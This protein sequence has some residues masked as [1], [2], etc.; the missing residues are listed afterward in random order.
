MGE[1]GGERSL[2]DRFPALRR[3]AISGRRR[4]R[5]RVPFVQQTTV[6]DCGAACLAM[7]LGHHGKTVR[8]DAVRDVAGVSGRGLNAGTLLEVGRHFGLRGRG[9][10][11]ADV[12]FLRFLEPGAILHWRFK[13]FVVFE[14]LGRRHVWIVD[15]AAGRRRVPR[16]EVARSF[17]GI[18]LTFEPGPDFEPGGRRRSGVGR[19]VR[20]I[21]GQSGLVSR[22]LVATLLLQ[23]LALSVPLLTGVL[24]DRV[25]PRADY[26][27]L[28]ILAAG[29][30]GL[31]GFQLLSALVRSFLLLHLRTRLEA[32]MSLEFLDHLVELPY[33]FF[34]LRPTG[35]LMMRLNSHA[36][37]REILT[38]AGISGVLDGGMATL[39]LVLLL[40]AD[41][42]IGLVV[43]GLGAVRVALFLFTRRRHRDLMSASLEAQA[44]SRSYQVQMLEGIATLK[45]S[46]AERRAVDHFANLFVDELNVTLSRGR[47]DAAV[48]A[49]LDALATAS[50]LVVLLYGGHQVLSGELTLGM[51]L[52]LAALAQGFLG[53]LSTLVSTLFQLQLL[54]SYLD[55]IDDVMEAPVEQDDARPRGAPVLRGRVAI[56]GVTFR[57]GA[58]QPPAVEDVSVEI[59]PGQVVAVVGLSGSGKSTLANLLAG[60][61]RPDSG[62]ILYDGRDLD[63]L[64][65]RR[66]RSQLGYVPQNPFVFAATL[67]ENI[68][69]GDPSLPLPR[70]QEAARQAAIHDEIAAMPLGYETRVASRGASLSGGQLQRVALARALASR[71]KILILDEATSA[72][73]ALTEERVYRNLE[74]LR[75]TRIVIAHRLSTVRG[76][77]LV[78]VMESGRVVERGTH[79]ELMGRDG[80][81]RRLVAAQ[82]ETQRT[83]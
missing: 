10:K 58:L 61:Y 48:N 13:H 8:L 34:Q 30:A 19:Y 41:L 21:L 77:D 60:L 76:A 69:L 23:V 44:E 38:T 2:L 66:L 54:G 22:I 29:L 36:T 33:K 14:R 64:D 59:E 52:A 65:L 17:T 26:D 46:G 40:L 6:A 62:R 53:P 18:A 71:P 43:A 4:R 83:A 37:V 11:V 35:D 5:G 78:L 15:P 56:E 70:L 75:A 68:A 28:R 3:L 72:L 55:R 79:A 57:Y 9:V 51:M 31:A 20:Q 47:L 27:L 49:I 42:E 7:V 1:P 74:A 39:Y 63:E 12:E 25:V 81:Y 67:R 24:V 80:A 32:R 45:A 82:A 16:A 73:D 50:P